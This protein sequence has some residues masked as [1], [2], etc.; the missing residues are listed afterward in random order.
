MNPTREEISEAVLK[1]RQDKQ[2][3]A[4]ELLYNAGF[5]AAYHTAYQ[6]TYEYDQ[7]QDLAQSSVIHGL[8]HIDQLG[9][10]ESYI[11]W[12]KKI[13][14]RKCLDYLKS[15]Y[16]QKNQTFTDI[17][18]ETNELEYDP[19]DEKIT[20]QPEE[21]LSEKTRTDIVKEVL[22]QLPETQKTI[23]MMYFYDNLTMNEI[24]DQL[25]VATSTVIG[26]L[27]MAK[28]TIKSA[29]TDIQR[30]GDIKLYNVSPVAVFMWLLGRFEATEEVPY[31]NV[32]IPEFKSA[33]GVVNTTKKAVLDSN[34]IIQQGAK[35]AAGVTKGATAGMSMAAK[36]GL[37][38][39]LLTGGG[40]AVYALM[41]NPEET[42]NIPHV[43]EKKPEKE[44]DKIPE[45]IKEE[46]KEDKQEKQ[47]ESK[48]E[49]KKE[50]PEKQEEQQPEQTPAVEDPTPVETP[51]VEQAVVTEPTPEPEAPA[52]PAL[53]PLPG[54]TE[55]ENIVWG[56]LGEGYTVVEAFSVKEYG[57][58]DAVKSAYINR[59]N[60]LVAEGHSYV[61]D[62]VYFD[63]E[64][65]TISILHMWIEGDIY[66][67][68]ITYDNA[69]NSGILADAGLFLAY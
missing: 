46:E 25:N 39:A 65:G 12:I 17:Y 4:V 35:T 24:A 10:P 44:K 54:A 57:S 30:R 51:P 68:G 42:A 3:N 9:K 36:I 40:G 38:I 14:E 37:S 47:E 19:E 67:D 2:S 56:Y 43:E 13:T 29:I 69:Y 52:Q 8:N 5:K 64:T 61:S 23:T 48:K 15:A 58:L 49:E 55:I 62:P 41:N 66:R 31:V 1:Y 6:F 53:L 33:E 27:Q 50:E 11:S 28:K 45:E 20:F 7:S 60:E 63:R 18:D 32:Q 59:T 26:R 22:S 21:Q 16:H 34:R